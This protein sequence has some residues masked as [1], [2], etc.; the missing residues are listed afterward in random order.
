MQ[1]KQVKKMAMSVA[2]TP[3]QSERLMEISEKTKILRST[4]IREGIDLIIAQYERQLGLS[5]L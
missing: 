1:M 3:Q 5:P 2:L 4:L